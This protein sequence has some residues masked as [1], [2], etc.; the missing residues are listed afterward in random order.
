MSI[1]FAKKFHLEFS[2]RR[3]SAPTTGVSHFEVK[4]AFVEYEL[5]PGFGGPC[6]D[7]PRADTSDASWP[8]RARFR[9]F[10]AAGTPT[11][12]IWIYWGVRG[13]PGGITWKFYGKKYTWTTVPAPNL[14]VWQDYSLDVEMTS[15]STFDLTLDVNNTTYTPTSIGST[16]GPITQSDGATVLTITGNADQPSFLLLTPLESADLEYQDDPMVYVDLFNSVEY[17]DQAWSATEVYRYGDSDLVSDSSSLSLAF[18]NVMEIIVGPYFSPNYIA[19]DYV[20]DGTLAGSAQINVDYSIVVEAAAT[21]AGDFQLVVSGGTQKETTLTAF[22]DAVMTVAG[23]KV[24][25]GTATLA[26]DFQSQVT[27]DL[28]SDLTQDLATDFQLTATLSGSILGQASLAADFQTDITA[29]RFLEAS[30]ALS[31]DFSSTCLGGRIVGPVELYPIEWQDIAEW[32]Q[33]PFAVW[34]KRGL[35]MAAEFTGVFNGGK[36]LEGAAGIDADSQLAALGGYLTEGAAAFE[37]TFDLEPGIGKITGGAALVISDVQLLAAAVVTLGAFV[38]LAGDFQSS[39]TA[40]MVFDESLAFESTFAV[41]T[42]ARRFRG[43]TETLSGST[44]IGAVPGLILGG[45]VTMPAFTAVLTVGTIFKVDEYRTIRVL[46]E[47]R[48]WS[49][50]QETRQVPV[51]PQSRQWLVEGYEI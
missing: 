31:A 35:L 21:L 14:N 8:F 41:D 16:F 7:F 10:P 27:A 9:S 18:N 25:L 45:Q 23:D 43:I 17:A 51:N 32:D 15:S 5:N 28:S 11:L 4:P 34:E 19:D 39:A 40:I 46:P 26:G 37:S 42:Q 38:D 36:I 6:P 20:A 47:N 48:A 44:Q 49:M 13:D 50:V 1:L 12:E 24:S 29:T 22:G 2:S 33:W 3:T 30:A